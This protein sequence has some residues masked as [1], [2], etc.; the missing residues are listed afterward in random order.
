[1][2]ICEET[3]PVIARYARSGRVVV[4]DTETPGMGS[5]NET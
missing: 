1:M 5:G 4:F 2:K 3:L